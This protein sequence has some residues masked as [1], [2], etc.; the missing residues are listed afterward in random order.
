M[1]IL[2]LEAFKSLDW[3]INSKVIAKDSLPIFFNLHPMDNS[4][5]IVG[6]KDFQRAQELRP[7]RPE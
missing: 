4:Y 3:K 1:K 2:I 5:V 7:R 6:D